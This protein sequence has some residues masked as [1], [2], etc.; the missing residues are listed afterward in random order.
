[1]FDLVAPTTFK[2]AIALLST[3]SAKNFCPV[4]FKL[5]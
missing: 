5:L 3:Q 4:E 1:M 2:N